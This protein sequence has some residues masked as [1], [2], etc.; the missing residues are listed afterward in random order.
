MAGP[1]KR[2]TW[3]MPEWGTAMYILCFSESKRPKCSKLRIVQSNLYVKKRD[4]NL[5]E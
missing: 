4:Q 5:A 3:S 2:A 1:P